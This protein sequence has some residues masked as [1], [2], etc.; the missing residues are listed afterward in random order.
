MPEYGFAVEFNVDPQGSELDADALSSDAVLHVADASAYDGAGTVE[1]NGIRYD[2]V[3]ADTD[4]GTVTLSASL[5]VA[6]SIGD[7]VYIVGGGEVAYDHTLEVHTAD[8]EPL[9]IALDFGDRALWGEPGP[10]DPPIPVT[11]SDD[12]TTIL[13]VPGRRARVTP[14]AIQAPLLVAHLDANQSFPDGAGFTAV[15]GWTV[16]ELRGGMQ[17]DATAG[18]AIVPVDGWYGTGDSALLWQAS[19]AGRRSIQPSFGT[20]AGTVPGGQINVAGDGS[21]Q[22]STPAA[23]P[24]KRLLAGESVTLTASQTSGGSLLLV[25]DPDGAKSF[26]CV[27]YRGPL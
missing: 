19:S 11:L 7:R 18:A 20:A 16:T 24:L 25:G 21:V 1:V 9:E 6:A 13:D 22:Q 23:S 4:A 27:E 15:T 3:D 12:L 10:I 17:Y 2:Y 14:S 8:G 26:F 5:G